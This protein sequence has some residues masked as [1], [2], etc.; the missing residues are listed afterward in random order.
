MAASRCVLA[1]VSASS[2]SSQYVEHEFGVARDLQKKILVVMRTGKHAP[3]N[4]KLAAAHDVV[5]ELIK[6]ETYLEE[7]EDGDMMEKQGG[8][9]TNGINTVFSARLI[10]K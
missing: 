1:V 2:I 10:F 8:N 3:S 5:R 6:R 4:D 7:V 9:L